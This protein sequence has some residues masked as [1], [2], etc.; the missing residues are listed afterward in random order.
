YTTL[1]YKINLVRG[2]TPETGEVRTEGWVVHGGRRTATAEGRITDAAGRLIGHGSTT[3]I[4]L[5]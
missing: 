2:M 3:C 1:E 5:S 4:I